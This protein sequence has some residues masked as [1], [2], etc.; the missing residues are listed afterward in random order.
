MQRARRA[1]KVFAVVPAA[2]TSRRLRVGG[3]VTKLFL[4]LRRRPLLIHTLQRLAASPLIDGIIAVVRRRDYHRIAALVQTHRV[5]KMLGLVAGGPTRTASVAAGVAAVPAD[6]EII[7]IH[8]GARPLV[9]SA[10]I[11]RT[12]H[13]ARRWGAAVAAVPIASTIKQRLDHTPVVTVDRRHLWAAQTPQAFRA[14]LIRRAYRQALRRRQDATD[15]AMLVERQGVRV[16]LV[17]GD[18]RNIKV[19]TPADLW[20]AEAFLTHATGD[21][22]RPRLRH[23]SPR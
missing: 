4:P 1:A 19:T 9:T 13:G 2:G 22:R 7:L 18:D 11:A 12:V 17:P 6:A 3:Q 15:D 23:P 14:T 16:R 10:V 8:D 21:A 20:A 5:P